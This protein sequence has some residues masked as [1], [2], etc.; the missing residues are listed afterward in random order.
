MGITQNQMGQV[1]SNF[2]QLPSMEHNNNRNNV[3]RLSKMAEYYIAV[4]NELTHQSVQETAFFAD[5]FAYRY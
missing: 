5:L 3:L 1:A 4:R 2:D